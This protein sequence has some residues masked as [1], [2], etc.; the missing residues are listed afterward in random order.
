[1]RSGRPPTLWWLLMVAD[2]PANRHRLDHVGIERALREERRRPRSCFA[3]SSNTSMKVTPMMRRFFSGSS[4]P[5]EVLRGSARR[6]RRARTSSAMR[7]RKSAIDVARA[8]SGAQQAVVDE[9]AGEPIADR[10]VDER[11]D[12]RR[13]DAAARARR[14]RAASPTRSRMRGDLALDE[15]L[16]RPVGL[17]RR[18]RGA[19]SS[20]RIS[21][22]VDAVR[23][24]GMELHAVER[25]L[26]VAEGRD[27]ASC[28]C[29][30]APRARRRGA[31]CGRRGSST[32]ASCGRRSASSG[33]TRVDAQRRPGRTPCA[34]RASTSP[35]NAQVEDVHAVADAE[36]RRHAGRAAGRG[37]RRAASA[38][39]R[40]RRSPGRPRG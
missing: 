12:D 17:A 34:R 1:M 11:R 35:P 24:L 13:V 28:R 4:T 33:S 15:V 7:S 37:P 29:W 38:R 23:D 2:G 5:G 40:R 25:P 19:R 27:T 26:A 14:R 21:L 31:S 18:R 22:P 39:R 32:R 3:S 10:A 8:S 16:H 20:R 6:R 36:H 30:R 9:D